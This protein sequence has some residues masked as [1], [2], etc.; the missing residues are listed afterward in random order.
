MNHN[1]TFKEFKVKFPVEALLHYLGNFCQI[2][3][4]HYYVLAVGVVHRESQLNIL[5]VKVVTFTSFTLAE[6]NYNEINSTFKM[7]FIGY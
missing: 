4:N 1:F 7:I 3:R 2:F 6:L 5:L